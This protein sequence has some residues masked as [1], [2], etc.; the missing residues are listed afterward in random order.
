MEKS[1]IMKQINVI[2]KKS[3]LLIFLINTTTMSILSP[4]KKTHTSDYVWHYPTLSG[5]STECFKNLPEC[6]SS[7][8]SKTIVPFDE[9]SG[10][11]Q[12][13]LVTYKSKKELSINK[14]L[15]I[16]NN[17][18]D[19]SLYSLTN[20]EKQELKNIFQNKITIN[21]TLSNAETNEEINKHIEHL[22]AHE[23]QSIFVQKINISSK[24]KYCIMGDIHASL[25]SLLR[26]LWNLVA[27][28]HLDDNFKIIDTNF[29][30]IFLGDYINIA[31]YGIEVLYTLMRLK[32]ANWNQVS[33]IR[34]NHEEVYAFAKNKDSHG[35]SDLHLFRNE[36]NDAF[37]D[38]QMKNSTLFFNMIENM[39]IFFRHLPRAIFLSFKGEKNSNRCIQC[40]HAGFNPFY[41][42]DQLLKEKNKFFE[43]I[44]TAATQEINLKKFYGYQGFSQHALLSTYDKKNKKIAQIDGFVLDIKRGNGFISDQQAQT[45]YM[46]NNNIVALLC[47]HYH[48]FYGLKMLKNGDQRPIHWKNVASKKEQDVHEIP[49]H[50]Y[51]NPIFT[52]STA[53]AAG[54]L[55]Y[56]CYG[57]LKTASNYD[58]WK[59]NVHEVHV[60]KTDV[61]EKQDQYVSIDFAK[62][63]QHNSLI[64]TWSTKQPKEPISK[65]LLNKLTF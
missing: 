10:T 13:I 4:T 14:N 56:D 36:L 40:S 55:P 8:D 51:T 37:N 64:T 63:F 57:I 7:K 31:T 15:W 33:F 19:Q 32:L 27:D 53:C 11:L 41:K 39:F 26:N 34:G 18:P 54:Y 48:D 25:H 38:Q 28:G 30:M 43:K 1:K 52:F 60:Y 29:T 17:S 5:W 35:I 9:F 21:E 42:T 23:S 24:D 61:K 6:S 16:N 22:V 2:L 49:L 58:D 44:D 12:K 20:D 45:N 62:N 50:L 46:K 65:A 47:G 3:L 59:L